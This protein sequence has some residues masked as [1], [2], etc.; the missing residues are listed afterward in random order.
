MRAYIYQATKSVTQS[1]E[2]VSKNWKLKFV[3]N[4]DVARDMMQQVEM[5]FSSKDS[6]IEFAKKNNISYD[7]IPPQEKKFC[8]KSYA[9]NFTFF[10]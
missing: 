2:P 3:E 5:K 7:L 9:E 6:A 10:R 1:A 8:K 4:D